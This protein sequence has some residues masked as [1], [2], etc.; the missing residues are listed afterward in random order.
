MQPD[1]PSTPGRPSTLERFQPVS[2]GVFVALSPIST[3][4]PAEIA[5]VKAQARSVLRRRAR[6]CLHRSS[7]DRLHD[8]VIA[9][10]RETY[11]RPHRHSDKSETF[12]VI[13]GSAS[14]VIF[15]EQG[16]IK[17]VIA[18]GGEQ[19]QRLYRMD[20]P[21]YHTLVIDSEMLVIHEVTN[22]PF[23]PGATDYAKFAP[24]EDNQASANAY[25]H[26]LRA[27][28]KTFGK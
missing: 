20:E 21:H 1:R 22:G 14:V 7:Y 8:M 12:H 18:L 23:S 25:L 10:D 19:G 26:N 15:D 4:G 16:D 9:L 5:F 3:V 28:L 27:R 6:L 24:A 17:R 2:E 13:E 11:L